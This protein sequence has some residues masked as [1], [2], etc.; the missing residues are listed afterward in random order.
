MFP[1]SVFEGDKESAVVSSFPLFKTVFCSVHAVIS[2]GSRAPE[3]TP[4]HHYDENVRT[5]NGQS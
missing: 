2:S 1:A 3:P 4:T 5:G